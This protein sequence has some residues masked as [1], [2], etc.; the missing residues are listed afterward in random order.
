MIA[1]TSWV[2]P[3]IV[4]AYIA[5]LFVVTW[6]SQRMMD[7]TSK[8]LVGYL[9]AGR[10]MPS[11]V[12][13]AALAG[14]A[15][16]GA[17]TIGVAERAYK[18]GVSA[19]WYN[20]A[21]AAGA[22]ITG[23]FAIRRYRRFE[24]STL[25]EL[26][27]RYYT[28]SGRVVAVVGQLA[29]QVVVTS[30]QYVA[31]GAILSSLMP[32][33]FTLRAGMVATAVVFVGITLVGGF[34]AAGLTN[35]VNVAVIYLGICVGTAV[36]V[37][38]AGGIAGLIARAPEGY[39]GYDLA[40]VGLP[41]IAAWFLVMATTAAST[42]SVVQ[43]GLAAKDERAAQHGFLLGALLIVPVG[44]LSALL[45]MAARALHP[46][47]APTE[48]LP[49]VVLEMPP[50]LAGIILAGLWAADVSTATALLIGSATL[51]TNDVVKRFAARDLDPVREK[52]VSRASV[53]V[54]GVA[55][56]VLAMSVSGILQTLMVG[57]TLTTGYTIV[58]LAT[59]YWPSMC[60]RG[61]ATW[62]LVG[63]M[64]ALGLWYAAPVEWAKVPMPSEIAWLTSHP[65]YFVWAMSV[66]SFL[67]VAWVD[68]RRIVA[69]TS[70]PRPEQGG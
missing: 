37:G 32:Q 17:S 50:L 6:W 9:L 20:A 56:F 42:Q 18:V 35:V 65:I 33:V 57:L 45:G 47:I 11:W 8:G 67:A 41:V 13:A 60:R 49:R 10:E 38:R 25:P 16:G 23:I 54:L 61:T 12:C 14:L 19:G 70:Q 62:T 2:P 7:R 43:I 15:V 22:L 31:G 21:W 68:R 24:V 64:A 55:T 30:L 34:W 58:V 3:V 28:P 4:V 40:G 1:V 36:T 51:V 29:I 48:A 53:L 5:L 44:F 59:M 46:G 52:W 27:E 63:T 69:G 26:I 66:V 39:P